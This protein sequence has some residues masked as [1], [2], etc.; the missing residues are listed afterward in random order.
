[1][2]YKFR[3][4]EIKRSCNK[5]YKKYSSYKSFL[6][7]DFKHRCAYCNLIDTATTTPF[8]VD[9]FIPRDSFKGILDELDT[10]YENLMYSC[11]KCN[12]AKGSKYSGK[13][14]KGVIEN[15]EFYNPVLTDMNDIFYRNE[16]GFIMSS[17]VKGREMILKMNLH[18]PIHAIG[19][20]VEKIKNFSEKIKKIIS[21]CTDVDKKIQY[22]QID[23]KL[24][25]YYIKIN[26]FF[27]SNYNKNTYL[28]IA[29][30][31][32]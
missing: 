11:K 13:L 27:T 6:E 28:N 23:Y 3:E 17:D 7:I 32:E 24:S 20:M 12:I 5:V 31:L 8:E 29:Q 26:S 19:W 21:L 15:L 22:E 25:T 9:H 30:L 2:Q 10:L 1:M 4:H 14:V 18:H 16:Y